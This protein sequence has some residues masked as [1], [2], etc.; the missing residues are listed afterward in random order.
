MVAGQRGESNADEQLGTYA[1][2]LQVLVIISL[3]SDRLLVIPAFFQAWARLRMAAV[4]EFVDAA[5]AGLADPDRL[6]SCGMA[7]PGD[8]D[9]LCAAAGVS[10]P[11]LVLIILT[12]SSPHRH[13][14]LT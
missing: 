3:Y 14:I 8:V 4:K 5:A 7:Q 6:V 13:L 10:S 9:A 11:H 2:N 12:Q 1:S